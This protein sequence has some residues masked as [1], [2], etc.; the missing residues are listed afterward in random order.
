M[1]AARTS[2][3]DE[4]IALIRELV[5]V[6]SANGQTPLLRL[7]RPF[8]TYDFVVEVYVLSKA[9]S[10]GHVSSAV[11][12]MATKMHQLFY[13]TL[14]VLLNLWSGAIEFGPVGVRAPG[15]LNWNWRNGW[16]IKGED[17]P[18]SSRRVYR[19]CIQGI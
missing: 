1:L 3:V 5:S 12:L 11:A 15:H 16:S 19:I 13:E 2:R 17:R 8:G 10:H 18:G 6:G 4:H 7:L 14:I 9:K